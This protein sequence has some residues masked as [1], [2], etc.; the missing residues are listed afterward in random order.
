MIIH[1]EQVPVAQWQRFALH[2]SAA[3]RFSVPNC[4][5]HAGASRHGAADGGVAAP[6]TQD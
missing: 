6:G 3:R 5:P 4:F 1:V 2:D